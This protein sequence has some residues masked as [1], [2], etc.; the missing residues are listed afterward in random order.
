MKNKNPSPWHIDQKTVAEKKLFRVYR[1]LDE[2]LCD[3]EDNREYK[4]GL[5]DRLYDAE[6]LA[7]RLNTE[8]AV[9]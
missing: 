1:N 5:Y 9:K 7:R 4:G 6:A 2:D 3:T 8:D